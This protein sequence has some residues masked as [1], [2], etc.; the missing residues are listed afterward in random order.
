V[1]LT[2]DGIA[3][4]L[5]YAGE[6]PAYCGLLQVNAIMPG[7][8]IPSGAEPVQLVVGVAVSPTITVWLE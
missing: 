5:L 3:A 7:G 6:A 2:V 1:T 8:L 4:Q